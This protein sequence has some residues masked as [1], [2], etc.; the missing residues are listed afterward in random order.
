[1]KVQGKSISARST[2][3][4][5]VPSQEHAVCICKRE[6]PVYLKAKGTGEGRSRNGR[7]GQISHRGSVDQERES[8]LYYV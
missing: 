5:K 1:M 8:G 7:C 3:S 6:R 2:A 4:A